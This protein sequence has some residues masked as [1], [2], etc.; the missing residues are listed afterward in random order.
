VKRLLVKIML[1]SKY[2]GVIRFCAYKINQF[3]IEPGQTKVST[4]F[5]ICLMTVDHS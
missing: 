1:E 5:Q 4:K 2:Y 3:T